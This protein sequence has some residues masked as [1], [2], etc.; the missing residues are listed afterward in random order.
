MDKNELPAIGILG[1]GKIGLAVAKRLLTAGYRVAGLS[2]DSMDEFVAAGGRAVANGAE[3][4]AITDIYVE[5]LGSEEGFE[6]V[7]HGPEGVVKAARKGQIMIALS[8][9]RLQ[10]KVQQQQRLAQYGIGHLD[11]TVSGG[12][13]KVDEG[14]AVVFVGGDT[15]LVERCRGVLNTISPVWHHVGDHGAATKLKF[16]NNTLSFVHN[17]AAAEAVALSVK[18]G[19]D[20]VKAVEFLKGG[21]GASPALLLR[22][23]RMAK[24]EYEPVIGDFHGALIVLESILEI[25]GEVDADLPLLNASLPYYK[26]GVDEGRADRDVT[27][28]FDLVMEKK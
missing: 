17:L 8:S 20:P 16:V 15:D 7:V 26:R 10:F 12:P 9:D 19:L 23:P 2:R 27:E 5:C 21:T 1:V 24:R 18:L 11:A 3:L 28:L 13:S 6:T 4:A 25:A 14:G 22:G